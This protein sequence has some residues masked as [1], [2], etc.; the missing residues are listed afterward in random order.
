[1]LWTVV[2]GVYAVYG[3]NCSKSCRTASRRTHPA[4][5]QSQADQT[6]SSRN[7]ICHVPL[8]VHTQ[9]QSQTGILRF[10]WVSCHLPSTTAP[11]PFCLPFYRQT[12]LAGSCTF[13]SGL[14]ISDTSFLLSL[15]QPTVSE[16]WRRLKALTP[17][18]VL[19]ICWFPTR[20]LVEGAFYAPCMV[21]SDSIIRQRQCHMSYYVVIHPEVFLLE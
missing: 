8:S 18:T 12:C 13:S 9:L 5:P 6:N 11:R 16:H 3:L 4:A 17:T 21:L 2:G 10:T 1:M 19:I 7:M 15:S 14:G 20:L